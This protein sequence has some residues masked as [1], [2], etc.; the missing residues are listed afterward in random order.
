MSRNNINEDSGIVPVQDFIELGDVP[1]SYVG[2][3]GLYP[4]VN[5]TEDG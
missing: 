2:Q 3:A 4:L 5:P 1:H